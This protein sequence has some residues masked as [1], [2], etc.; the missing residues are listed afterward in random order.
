[1]KTLAGFLLI[2]LAIFLV[3][4]IAMTIALYEKPYEVC[5]TSVRETKALTTEIL[6][7]PN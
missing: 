2:V 1:M 5:Y 3:G 6:N 4:I 7:F